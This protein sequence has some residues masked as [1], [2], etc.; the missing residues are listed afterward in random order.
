M[1][2]IFMSFDKKYFQYNFTVTTV[3]WLI[4]YFLYSLDY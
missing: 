2:D 1:F 3:C 4:I